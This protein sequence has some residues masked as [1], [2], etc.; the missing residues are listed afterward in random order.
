MSKLD[1]LSLSDIEDALGFIP[2][3]DREL[4]IKMGMALYDEYGETAF[5]AWD[6]WSQFS[7]NYEQKAAASSWKSFSR[8]SGSGKNATIASVIY[9]AKQ[10]GWKPAKSAPPDPAILKAHAD[11]RERRRLE[12]AQKAEA[13]AFAAA[14]KARDIWN[15]AEPASPNHG[16]LKNKS[17]G[18]YNLRQA[19]AVS[20][21]F[22][23]ED[24]GEI[25]AYTVK[26]ALLVAAM[27]DSR[28]LSSLQ[29]ITADGKKR[30]MLD[31]AMAGA[32]AK[33]GT[34]SN[35]TEHLYIAEGYAT[36]A[37]VHEATGALVVVAFN[38]GNIPAVAAKMRK[39]LPNCR[40]TIAAD[41]DRNTNGNPGVKSA[42]Q[43][44]ESVGA[45]VLVPQFA[46]ED[47]DATDWNDF[48]KLYGMDALKRCF[49][50]PTHPPPLDK[51]PEPKPTP[52]PEIKT[53]AEL[54]VHPSDRNAGK[55]SVLEW[56]S[57]LECT[58]K[59]AFHNNLDNV[60]RV[61][62]HDP[63]LRGF[64]WYDEF[65]DQIVTTWQG[66]E[67]SW[68]DSD[69]VLLQLYVQR[70]IGLTRVGVNTC[71]DAALVAAFR[72][73]RNECKEYLLSR[74]WDGVPRLER[75]MSTGFG[76][77]YD[78]YSAA[79]GR[80]WFTSM[81]ARVIRPGC[82]V[83]TVPVLEGSQGAGKSTA[84]SI[85]G[86]KWFTECH[87]SVLTK[88]FY[89]VLDGHMLV[90][91]SEMHSFTR[92]EVERVKGII[93]CQVDKYRK[94]YGRNT[95]PHPRKTVLACTT[96]RDD[97]QRDDTGARRFWPISCNAIDLDWLRENRDLL[98][99]EAV[100]LFQNRAEWW[101]VPKEQ[102]EY[103][104][105]KRRDVDVWEPIVEEWLVGKVRARADE[106]LR[107]AVNVETARQ[108]QMVQKRMSRIMKNLGWRVCVT[109]ENGRSFR[110][111][112]KN[113]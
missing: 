102:Q 80:C 82:K 91:I 38:A 10:R 89:G 47:T 23:D 73:V 96:N 104:V 27:Q 44:A 34:V 29:V 18:A 79:V 62:E 5:N 92:A 67:R 21:D 1:Y 86:G 59:G 101:D 107:D 41:N 103:E 45:D 58:D 48:H 108:D 88:D 28:T 35:T 16:Y 4:W 78:A 42:N 57:I 97:W 43:A 90:E 8:S 93:S 100:Y 36:G 22:I 94:A 11:E 85:I 31:G 95:E 25:K 7:P 111:W 14:Q 20:L 12:A 17:V 50:V 30:F 3:D 75:L 83:D 61:I 98:F 56:R 39:A 110:E 55:L 77:D 52:Q 71:H 72:N 33:I 9:E 19:S 87:E 51:K 13:R 6:S 54:Q 84:L 74:Q 15:S 105:E 106:V 99:A 37:S 46:D 70:H 32:Y 24:T 60:V 66:P 49:S 63:D 68:R 113:P 64:I 40:I 112:R 2:S 81:V 53:P 76:A 26:D 69:D 109:K 65:L